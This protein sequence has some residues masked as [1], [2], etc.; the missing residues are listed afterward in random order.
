MANMTSEELQIFRIQN[1]IRSLKMK[2]KN[3]DEVDI[4]GRLDRLKKTNPGMADEL[5]NQYMN[6]LN[7]RNDDNFLTA[8]KPLKRKW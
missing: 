4:R 7:R 5:E 2:T 6:V 8:K 1:E 3:I